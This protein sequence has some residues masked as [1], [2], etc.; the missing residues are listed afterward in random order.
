MHPASTQLSQEWRVDDQT[1]LNRVI[2]FRIGLDA[3]PPGWLHAHGG[4]WSR[5]LGSLVLGRR[6]RAIWTAMKSP[7]RR[8]LEWLLGRIAAKDAVRDYLQKRF[9]LTLHPTDV[10]IL[11]DPSGRPVATG[12]WTNLVPRVPLVSISHV[13]G[14]AV[15]VLTDGDDI[16][17]VGVD[18]ERCGRMTAEME[19]VAF[20]AR[21]RELLDG[22]KG[23]EQQSWALR[24]WCAKEAL[25]K[26]TGGD[27]SP[28][29]S[30]LTVEEIHHHD[31]AV[32]M[33]Y[34]TPNGGSA[35]VSA[36][37]MRDGDWIVATCIR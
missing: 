20:T 32:V 23:D 6:E 3:F 22:L 13:D 10:E 8:R 35:V 2:A 33:R 27:V 34:A 30:G 16:S 18:L 36:A 21:E 15:A 28:V 25:T 12:A 9:H 19:N 37:T 14:A 4:M 31:G 29:S 17:G 5:V 24:V 7:E 11:P 1:A 26:A